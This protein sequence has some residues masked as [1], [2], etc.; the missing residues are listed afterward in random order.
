MATTSLLTEQVARQAGIELA[1]LETVDA[2]N[3]AVDGAD[4]VDPDFNC[5]KGGGGNLTR[6]KVIESIV[7]RFVLVVGEEKIVDRLGKTFP[8]FIEVI[9]FARPVVIRK[10]QAM[11]AVVTQ[12]MNSDGTPFLTDNGNPYLHVT[13]NHGG[14]LAGNAAGAA[15]SS[16]LYDAAA[17]DAALHRIPGIVETGLF[18]N[19][20]DEVIVAYTDGRVEHRK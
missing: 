9:E 5:I 8:V 1:T 14:H 11:D 15:R 12:R 13:F 18:I 19:M 4:E 7:N 17:V 20:V 6:E 2:L 16:Q 10:L 3:I